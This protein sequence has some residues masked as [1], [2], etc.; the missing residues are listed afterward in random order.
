M[1]TTRANGANSASLPVARSSKR[2]PSTSSRSLSCTA[3]LAARVPC[4]PSMPSDCGWLAGRAPRPR[5]VITVGMAL[6]STKSRRSC[7]AS[8]SAMPP[9]A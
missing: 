2:A 6:A 7:T 8:P 3:M 4:M 5:S 1:W 9:P